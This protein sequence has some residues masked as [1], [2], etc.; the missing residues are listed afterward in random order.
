MGGGG[1]GVRGGGA[2]AERDSGGE[3]GKLDKPAEVEPTP[4]AI[5]ATYFADKPVQR[6]WAAGAAVFAETS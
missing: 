1:G 2:G 3:R 5:P 6:V 4:R